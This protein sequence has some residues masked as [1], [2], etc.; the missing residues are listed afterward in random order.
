[1][2]SRRLLLCFCCL[3]FF[4]PLAAQ[5][6]VF[7]VGLAVGTSWEIDHFSRQIPEA[8][9]DGGFGYGIKAIIGYELGNFQFAL[10]PQLLRQNTRAFIIPK[11]DV[12]NGADE[13]I[14]RTAILLPVRVDYRFGRQ[15]FRPL[16][17]VGGGF[18]LDAARDPMARLRP[19]PILPFIEVAV[20]VEWRTG[21]L[22][23]RPE[24]TVRNG[25]GELFALGGG[26]FNSLLIGQRWAFVSFGLVV[27][28]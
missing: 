14:Y 27:T 13:R 3:L 7:G 5:R 21:K 22:A 12:P 4:L 15:R 25:T 11:D 6:T 9:V 16:L 19:E 2:K 17:G 23:W 24:V 10:R 18:L 8:G 20:G 1:M 26:P 28:K